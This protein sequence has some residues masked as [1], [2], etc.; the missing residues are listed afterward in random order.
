MR[1]KTAKRFHRKAHVFSAGGFQPGFTL[2]EL[3]VVI[4]II[5]ILAAMLLP[6]LSKAKER[7]QSIRCVNN[8]KQLNL[9]W[10]LYSGDHEERVVCNWALTS[11]IR[12]TPESW[13]GGSVQ[14]AT[15]ATN[16]SLIKNGTLYSFNPN[17]GIYQ[18]PSARPPSPAGATILPVRTVSLNARMGGAVAGNSS[19]LGTVFQLASFFPMIT[20]TSSIQNPGPVNALSFI[21]ESLQGIDDGL[22]MLDCNQTGIWR[23][24]PTVRHGQGATLAF[25]DGHTERWKWQSL[26]A[27]QAGNVSATGSLADLARLQNTIYTP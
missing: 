20:K 1:E 5:A 19:S 4:A 13:V 21:D 17:P 10:I 2:I 3:L 14:D 18:C 12:S 27:E 25:A 26:N 9:G 16:D 23:N 7:A 22:F 6:A 15:D 11:T 24:S 8:L